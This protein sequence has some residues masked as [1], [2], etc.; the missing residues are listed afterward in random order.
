MK[1]DIV[2]K[3]GFKYK[4]DT[5]KCHECNGNCCNGESGYVWVTADEIRAIANFLEIELNPFIPDYLREIFGRYSLKELKIMNNYSCVFFD[6]NKKK[7]SIYSVRPKQCQDF[8]F[9]ESMKNDR[10]YLE[11]ECPGIK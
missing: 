8:P 4:F 1:N 11:K 3:D 5:S 9:W 7:C 6:E 10:T 2:Q